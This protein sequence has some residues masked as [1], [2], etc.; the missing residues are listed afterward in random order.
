MRELVQFCVLTVQNTAVLMAS[1]DPQTQ[2]PDRQHHVDFTEGKPRP[3]HL[4]PLSPA[5]R[6]EEPALPL[7]HPSV[8]KKI[9]SHI[10]EHVAF[11]T[12]V[13]QRAAES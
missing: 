5:L 10:E 7:L 2:Y 13:P 3:G 12:D 11:N 8:V 4:A 1:P 6:W 9:T